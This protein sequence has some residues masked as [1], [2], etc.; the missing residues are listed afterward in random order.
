[1]VEVWKDIKGYEGL[2]QISNFGNIRSLNY[3]RRKEIHLLKPDKTKN[4]YLQ[5]NLYNKT[6]KKRHYIHRL[7]AEAFIPNPNNLPQVNHKDENKENNYVNNLEW[8]THEYNTNYGNRN[9]NHSEKMKK[10]K[11]ENHH[12]WGK[13]LSEETRKKMS[14]SLKGKNV[15]IDNHA[16]KSVI[17]LTTKRIF[18]TIT[19]ASKY[20]DCCRSSI[21]LC[22]RG[23][24]KSCGKYQG[25]KLV[26]RFL[27]WEHNKKYRKKIK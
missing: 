3:K 16:S 13:H 1:M 21:S 4:G 23:K 8:C 2:Y 24:L 10:Y 12:L 11:G 20:Y 9:K 7:V 18:Y 25:Q 26:W 6:N 27:V 14:N 22:C 5:I 19:E 17:C 15:G